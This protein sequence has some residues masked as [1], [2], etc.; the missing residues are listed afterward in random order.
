MLF[1]FST[2][3]FYVN[4]KEVNSKILSIAHRGASGYAP[5]NTFAAFDKAIEMDVDYLELDVQMTK[6]NHLVIIHDP[7]VNRTT[8][9]K[10]FVKDL[11]LSQIKSLD[12]GSW[13]GEEFRGERIPT[14]KEI[15]NVYGDKVGLLVELKNPSLYPGIEK[16]VSDAINN[17]SLFSEQ[18]PSIK[19]QSFDL[20]S[21]RSLKKHLPLIDVG[22]LI[23]RM[24]NYRKLL[25]VEKDIDF[26]N[27]QKRYIT[28]HI[29][30]QAHQLNLK[31]YA[32][33]VNEL[34]DLTYL[35]HLGIDG[36]IVDYPEIIFKLQK[37]Y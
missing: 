21:L 6:D 13:F 36:A 26:I 15:L 18:N 2:I 29:V 33:T 12:A 20:S 37:I 3:P 28:R 24:I 4:V 22:L 34:R 14:F 5:E 19:V 27:M 8:N 7:K 23:N 32:W 16:K 10:G 11:T 35:L 17:Y 1:I 9:G 31:I 25:K 30:L